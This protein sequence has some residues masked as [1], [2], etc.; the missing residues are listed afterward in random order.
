MN[1]VDPHRPVEVACLGQYTADVVVR[2]VEA[3]PEKG[4]AL[5]VDDISLTNGGSACNA[6]VALG[7][8]GA[9]AAAIGKVGGDAFGAFVLS[10]LREAGVD[11][12]S[13][14]QDAAV[15]TS[16]TAVMVAADGERS[17]LHYFGGNSAMT[18]ACIDWEMIRRSRILHVA[19]AFLVPGLDGEPMA[20]AL[21]RARSMGTLTSLDTAWDASGRW[22]EVLEPCL[23]HL[24]LFVPS[25]EEARMLTGET[26]PP[27]M[28]RAFACRGVSTTVIKLGEDGCYVRTR[29][30]EFRIPAYPV[31]RVVDTLGAGDAFAGGLLAGLARG[32]DLESACRL[33][34]AAGASCVGA[35]GLTG[36]RPLAETAARYDVRETVSGNE[37]HDAMSAGEKGKEIP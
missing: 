23:P 15:K 26:E 8:L 13:M 21:A 14:V 36:I 33:A 31:A 30:R 12:S 9:R 27:E 1:A 28:A 11:V 7:K 20:R 18:E 34:C 29:G 4:K 2:T 10:T 17:F 24:D 35:A 32:W 37:G 19:A 22:M 3:F 5:F 6:A 25:R 16:T